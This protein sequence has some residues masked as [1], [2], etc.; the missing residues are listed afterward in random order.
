MVLGDFNIFPGANYM[1]NFIIVTISSININYH[2]RRFFF[3]ILRQLY[4]Y[5]TD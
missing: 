2:R 3:L 4:I 1:I 5:T